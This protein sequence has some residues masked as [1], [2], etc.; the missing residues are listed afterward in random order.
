MSYW[1][2][3]EVYVLVTAIIL[4][5]FAV[6][7]YQLAVQFQIE[8]SR[9]LNDCSNPLAIYFDNDIRNKCL[10]EH[11]ATKNEDV[12]KIQKIM[13]KFDQDTAP[14]L[15]KSMQ[16]LIDKNTLSN[17]NYE[18]V[19]DNLSKNEAQE[20]LNGK[21]SLIDLSGVITTIKTQYQEN[22][23]DLM[24]LVD[25]YENRV[26]TNIRFIV[27]VGNSLVNKLLSNIYTK[28]FE[29]KRKTIVDEYQRIKTYLDNLIK[30]KQID[31]KDGF[32]RDLTKDEMKGK[33]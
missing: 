3:N 33:Q 2:F 18:N 12:K 31:P 19:Q 26:N 5:V 13:K 7:I 20:I 10:H 21:Q 1:E 28:K 29:E 30:T 9:E 17:L 23:K 16:D 24:N 11:I 22:S 8:I 25:D 27:D 15:E 6:L 14:S 4:I 32:L